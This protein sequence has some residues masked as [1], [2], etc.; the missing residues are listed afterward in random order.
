LTLTLATS[1]AVLAEF[2]HLLD[3]HPKAR[4]TA[5]AI[6]RSGVLTL[7][8]AGEGDLPRLDELVERYA[9]WPMDF[10]DATRVRFAEREGLSAVVTIDHVD[11]E[12]YH[13]AGRRRFRILPDC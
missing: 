8:P 6:V 5:W 1:A 10:A 11:F 3:D 12:T 4:R 13:I 2:F 9:D 7:L